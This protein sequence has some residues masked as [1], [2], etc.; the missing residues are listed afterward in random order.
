MYSH[1]DLLPFKSPLDSLDTC[2]RD[3]LS[4]SNLLLLPLILARN[5]LVIRVIGGDE[6]IVFTI[7]FWLAFDIRSY[8][9]YHLFFLSQF[10]LISRDDVPPFVEMDVRDTES[11][12]VDGIVVVSMMLMLVRVRVLLELLLMMMRLSLVMVVVTRLELVLRISRRSSQEDLVSM[13]VTD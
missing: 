2:P 3:L 8:F 11:D 1:F 6:V 9:L 4:C 10:D 12:S 13:V 7:H 5:K